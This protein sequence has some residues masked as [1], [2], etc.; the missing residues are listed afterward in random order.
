MPL[1]KLGFPLLAAALAALTVAVLSAD[2][3]ESAWRYYR[4]V[5][6]PSGLAD[7]S[8]VELVPEVGVFPFAALGLADLRVVEIGRA[9]V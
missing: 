3:S 6:L 7:D 2:F 4:P 1:F 5:L 8:L 9:H